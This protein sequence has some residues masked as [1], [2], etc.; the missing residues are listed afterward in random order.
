MVIYHGDKARQG[1]HTQQGQIG[2]AQHLTCGDVGLIDD[3]PPVF[4]GGYHTEYVMPDTHVGFLAGAKIHN[5]LQ[6]QT[7]QADF[8]LH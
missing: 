8:N 3:L 7:L 5:Y 4:W 2:A 6:I 1:Q